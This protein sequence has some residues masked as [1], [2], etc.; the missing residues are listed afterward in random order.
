MTKTYIFAN[1][2]DPLIA[3]LAALEECCPGITVQDALQ[4][5]AVDEDSKAIVEALF[6]ATDPRHHEPF[7]PDSAARLEA[8]FAAKD[9]LDRV[10]IR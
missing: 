5:A 4:V 7:S 10:G 6:N 3:A 8:E 9:I 2:S 1:P